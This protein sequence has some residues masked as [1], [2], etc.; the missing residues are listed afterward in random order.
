[1]QG[2]V[3]T[4]A[5]N[6]STAGEVVGIAFRN[7]DTGFSI[8]RVR[9]E[10]VRDP[11]TVT[12]TSLVTPGEFITATGQWRVHPSFGRQFEAQ[13]ILTSRPTSPLA[14]ERYLASGVIKGIG[15]AMAARIVRAFGEATFTVLDETPEKLATIPGIGPKRVEELKA[16]WAET[17]ATREIQVFLA[18]HDINGALAHR[19]MRQYGAGTIELVE[20]EPYRL[21]K[22]VRGIGFTTADTIAKRMGIPETHPARIEAGLRHAASMASGNGHCGVPLGQFQR[23]AQEALG[24][25]LDWI[26]PVLNEQLRQ[27]E[28]IVPAATETDRY[29]FDRRLFDA[30]QRIAAALRVMCQEAAPWVMRREAAESVAAEAEAACGV[31]LATEQREAV[32][33]ALVARVSVLTGGPGTGKTSTLKVIL[34]ALNRV[35]ARVK[36]AAP[37]GKAAKRMR[38]TT[39]HEASTVARLIGMGSGADDPVIDCDILVVDE[40]S[41]VDVQMLDKVLR[42]MTHG[43][44]ILFVGDVDQLPSVGPGRVLGDL[45]ESGALPTVR[46]T[47]V[48]RQA[49]TSAIIRNAHRINRGEGIEVPTPGE[50]C[51]FYFI[52]AESPEAITARIV[53][54]VRKDIP[55]RIQ[56]P[57]NDVQVLSP[58]RRTPTGAE[59]LNR[60]LQS[61]LNPAPSAKVERFGR[62]FGVG[63]RVLQTVN[64]YDLG[65]MNGESGIITGVDTEN[66]VLT[67]Q[68]DGEDVVYPF[69][70]LD[71]LDLAYAMSVH[72]SQGSQFPAVVVPVT[73]QHYMMLQRPIIYTAITRATRFCV[74]VGQRRALDMAIKNARLE[75]RITS[76][77][78][79][80]TA[81]A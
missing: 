40:A 78:R 4:A 25:S 26:N 31:T 12:G 15:P 42:C 45:I 69:A 6:E 76:L 34:T 60:L 79:R 38:E 36:L 48:F 68:V 75:P 35:R 22:E 64:N 50:P 51:D 32:I 20:R 3:A 71:Q 19:I 65:V 70:E 7:D 67:V 13:S 39:G 21:A 28:F 81:A 33:Q 24:L 23:A 66:G 61:A 47:Q 73:T 27:R 55:D 43:A 37:T 77:G 8:L 49:A 80:L 58:M 5:S 1:M 62:Q 2:G 10:G 30:E 54:L 53:S 17:R 57:S 18:S 14:I 52:P 41:M 72:K 44:A 46:L 74:L 11:V 29:V 16:V 56:I 63:D 59:N 9:V